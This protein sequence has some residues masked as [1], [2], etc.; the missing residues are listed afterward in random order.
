MKKLT[1][2]RGIKSGEIAQYP[3]V[4]AF[5]TV[6]VAMWAFFATISLNC[7]PAVRNLE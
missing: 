3:V 6:G 2:E 4:R 7:P 1:K 5:S